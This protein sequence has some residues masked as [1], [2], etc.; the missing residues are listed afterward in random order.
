MTLKAGDKAPGFTAMDQDGKEI[1]LND[2]KGKKVA[3]YFYPKDDTPGCTEQAC[4]LRDNFSALKQKGVVVLGVSI[5]PV[6]KHK[7]FETKYTLPFTLVSDE[8]KAIVNEY[9]LWAEKKFWGK[10]YMGTMRTTFLINEDGV[11]DHIIDKV[12]TKEHT[13]QI[14]DTWGI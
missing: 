12:D 14:I 9:G 5:D 13:Q 4:N 10:T 2:Y 6:K 3:L 1:S 7:K 8:D 11:I